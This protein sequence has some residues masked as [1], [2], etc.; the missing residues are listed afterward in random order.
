[1]RR[2]EA[3]FLAVLAAE[4]EQRLAHLEALRALDEP[5]PV[6]GAAELAVGDRFETGVLLQGDGPA[7][8]R[9]L[10]LAE[11]GRGDGAGVEGAPRLAQGR[12]PEQA[13]DVVGAER[14]VRCCRDCGLRGRD[15]P[16]RP[17]RSRPMISFMISEVPP[18]MRL[19]RLSDQARA[20]GY[21][22]M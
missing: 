14:R 13:A 18:A 6:G 22:H 3:G 9:V 10:S 4:A 16:Q 12:G 1:M 5:R 11:R 8:G 17:S 20:M 15:V 19:M 7:D 21:S 2:G